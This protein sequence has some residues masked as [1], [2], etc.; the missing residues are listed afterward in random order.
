MTAVAQRWNT[1]FGFLMASV[2]FAVGLGNIWRFPYVTGEN[3]G[4]AFVLVYL[5]CTFGIGIPI[6][7]A[8]LMLGRQGRLTPPPAMA[9]VASD[10]GL[11]RHWSMVG[12]LNLLTA[13]SI[14]VTYA[15]VCGWVLY[16]LYLALIGDLV[17]ADAASSGVRFDALLADAPTLT[18][19][20]L[21]ALVIASGIIYRGVQRG[22]ERAVTVLMPLLFLLLIALVGFN[23]VAGGIA[24]T[25]AYL[26][27]PDFSK[28]G[29]SMLLAA[30]GQSFFSIGVAMAGMMMFGAY[31]SDTVSIGRSAFLIVMADT[32]VALLAGFV[33]FP[34]VFNN[35]LDPA[36]GTGLIF[37]TLP[38]A[39]GQMPGGEWIGVLFFLLLSVA[40]VTSIVGF[41][42][43]LGA[44]LA[45]RSGWS[46]HRASVVLGVTAMTCSFVSVLSYNHWAQISVFSVSLNVVMDFVP[47]QVLLPLGGL[48]IALFAGWFVRSEYSASALN[49]EGK[50]LFQLWQVLLRFVVVPALAIILVTGIY[51]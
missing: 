24:E 14:L 35:G 41:C 36:Q 28:L 27:K 40:A 21:V 42:E 3:G 18:G 20:A 8:E 50:R 33:I 45:Q 1:R 38:L 26:L 39:F 4:S 25:L 30:I 32:L 16:Y 29:P 34:M 11:S 19:W 43:P 7:M 17:S 49:L 46:R 2:G 37:K 5:V 6:V 13:F 9:A 51:G 48:C 44:W 22:I 10:N 31:L 23:V 12:Y 47:N 15:V